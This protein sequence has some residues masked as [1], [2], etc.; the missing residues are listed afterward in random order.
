MIDGL[1]YGLSLAD[2]HEDLFRNIVSLRV[3]ED[4]ND[5]LSDDPAERQAATS[6]ELEFKPRS[7]ESPIPVI[8]RPFEEATWND[9]IGFPFANW[10]KSRFSDGSF[11]VWYG[12]MDIET[13]VHETVY[14][15]VRRLLEDADGYLKPGVTIERKIYR[16]HCDAAVIDFRKAV[17]KHPELVHPTDYSFTHQVGAR[18]DREGHP[19]LVS[20]SARCDGDNFVIFNPGVLSNPRQNCFLTYTTTRKGV[21]VERSPG[22]RWLEIPYS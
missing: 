6:I 18:L 12:C 17:K 9:A 4:L 10:M 7:F 16:V 3:S 13:T 11:G 20:R 22:R 21:I 2:V 15:W 8:Y 19:G 1:L 5:D 14:H